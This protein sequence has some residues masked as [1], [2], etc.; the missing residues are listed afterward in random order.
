MN[1][2]SKTRRKVSSSA[3][4]IRTTVALATLSISCGRVVPP[5]PRNEV[6]TRQQQRYTVTDSMQAPVASDSF[7]LATALDAERRLRAFRAVHQ[8]A[9]HIGT[10]P[11]EI[12]EYHDEQPLAD[13]TGGYGPMAY[14]FASPFIGGFTS[15]TQID[16]HGPYGFLAGVVFVEAPVGTTLPPT[17]TALGLV[18][19]LNCVYL[20]HQ[21]ASEQLGWDAYIVSGSET[22]GCPRP[23]DADTRHVAAKFQRQGTF[24]NQT[25][26]PSVGRFD[27][28]NGGQPLVGFRCIDAWCDVGPGPNLDVRPPSHNGVT[29]FGNKREAA[30]PGWH[31]DQLLAVQTPG[32][33][34]PRLRATVV[35]EPDLATKPISEFKGVWVRV[36]TVWLGGDP[37]GTKYGAPTAGMPHT[38]NM[39]RGLN[40]LELSF[41]GVSW[42][43]RVYPVSANGYTPTTTGVTRL[44][45]TQE[46]H[47][48]VLVPG[49]ARFRWR[50]ADEG[51]WVPCDQGCCR[52][53]AEIF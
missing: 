5:Q 26:Y 39:R 15:V 16:A 12:P 40:A 17:Y 1:A 32:G 46:K 29:F 42:Q 20:A 6:I 13:G 43:G 7:K 3:S 25:D 38:W 21:G 8:V 28:T 11:W 52:V 9:A 50:V 2:Q 37:S 35:P 22:T 41:D 49:T 53:E 24:N 34:R 36:A 48:D 4:A 23:M 45:V 33:L 31:D 27:E 19:G 18:P 14:V 10:L 47:L 30:V 51:I 44:I